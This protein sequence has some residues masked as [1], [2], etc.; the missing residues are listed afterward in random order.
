MIDWG[1]W[2]DRRTADAVVQ[3]MALG[4]IDYYAL[5]PWRSPDEQFL[6][7]VAEFVHEWSR[8]DSS[9]PSEITVVGEQ[10]DP[11]A[12]ALRSLLAR[13]GIPHA[14]HTCDSQRGRGGARILRAA[15][16]HGAG[17][18]PVGRACARGPVA[19]RARNRL[20]GEDRARVGRRVRRRGRRRRAGRPRRRGLRR[21][22]GPANAGRGARFGRRAGGIE[23]A[24]AQLPGLP[25]RPER[26]RTRAARLPAGMGLRCGA[27]SDVRGDR[28][29][30][31][32][33]PL[34]AERSRTARASARPRSCS[35]PGSPTGGSA[36]PRSSG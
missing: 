21:V 22:G 13:A 28:D 11:R 6:R 17:G 2:A 25:A 1:G 15:R 3:A 24:G 33:E 20:R 8:A 16:D 31:A 7:T 29:G 27:A 34:R 12:H 19:G 35:R 9:Q 18:Q 10:W 32:T 26:S 5:K 30:R 4:R 36:S 23:R 14:F